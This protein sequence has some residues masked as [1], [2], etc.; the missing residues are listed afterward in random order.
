[1]EAAVL[2]E[3]RAHAAVPLL[4]PARK[5]ATRKPAVAGKGTPM[6]RRA[7]LDALALCGDPAVAAERAGL[8]LMALVQLRARDAQFAAR[9]R[10]AI[11]F[12][13]ERVEHRLLAQLLDSG[14]AFDSKVALA[15]MARRDQGSPRG[16]AP[17]V[18]S[19]AVA[20]VRAELRALTEPAGR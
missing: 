17:T 18:D 10:A 16:Q 8:R 1:M 7:F 9:W 15:A 5:M 2:T 13:W 3:Q 20:R 12:A 6:A 14:A 19:A 4:V 11:D